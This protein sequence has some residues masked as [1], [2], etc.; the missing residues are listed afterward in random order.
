MSPVS[1]SSE[2]FLYEQVEG[3]VK[4]M[5][6]EGVLK[7]GER[8]PSIRAMSRKARV[9]MA[10][11]MQAYLAL[12]NKGYVESRPKSGF[13]V[14]PRRG[15]EASV[16]RKSNPRMLP[17]RVERQDLIDSILAASHESSIVSLGIANPSPE[18]L[19]VKGLTRALKQVASRY[20]LEAM[21][22]CFERG[23]HA[24]LRKQIALR[25]ADLGCS[26]SPSEVLTTVGT[27]EA[28]A[29]ALN[30][31]AR[32]GDVIAVES[33]TYFHILQLIE[34]LGMLALEVRTDPDTGMDL[35][36]L[37]QALDTHPVKAVMSVANFSNPLGSLMPDAA[38]RELV[39]LLSRHGIPLIEDDIYGDLYFGE[40]R[41]RIAKCF[42]REGL[43]L[44]CSSFSKTIAPGYRVGWLLP[45]KFADAATKWKL[46]M[47]GVSAA[48]P[49]LA[50]AEFLRTGNYDRHLRRLRKAY[51]DQVE[52]MRYAIADAF[53][54][55]TRITRPSGGFVL[56]VQLPK[57][58]DA[59]ALFKKS[60]AE[61]VSVTP[62]VLFS[63]TARF[64]NCIR[65]SCGLPW[66]ERI[67]VAVASIGRIARALAAGDRH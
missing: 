27:T 65:V 42:D 63:S 49:Q 53:P 14:R 10:T 47:S 57:Q 26:I 21:E 43:V 4:G 67:E 7:T 1:A 3:L 16:P 44:T 28:L 5:I 50:I 41:P 22:Y 15:P 59:I 20:P 51:R 60:L 55:G 8:V 25:G 29:V 11:V 18:L 54:D 61:G 32:P 56:W 39:E 19:P 30:T 62:G 2:S 36:A 64:N 24:E 33:P 37:A 52:Q 46:S 45:G 38:K 31:V 13:Y 17:R 12:E 9:S 66:S 6:D 35:D 58:I 23:G 48:L 34:R 40:R